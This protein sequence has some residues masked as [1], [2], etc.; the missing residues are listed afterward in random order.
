[1]CG[2]HDYLP[3]DFDFLDGK[4]HEKPTTPQIPHVE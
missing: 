1:M 2:Q 4:C 3:S